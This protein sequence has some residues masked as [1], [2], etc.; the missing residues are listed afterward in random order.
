M[1][2]ITFHNTILSSHSSSTDIINSRNTKKYLVHVIAKLALSA[3]LYRLSR[4][5]K[6]APV[7]FTRSLSTIM[8]MKGECLLFFGLIKFKT[9]LDI[10]MMT[11]TSELGKWVLLRFFPKSRLSDGTFG[12]WFLLF[13]VSLIAVHTPDPEYRRSR[14]ERGFNIVGGLM[15]FR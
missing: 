10:F 2:S 12:Q 4:N 8:V 14:G 11:A 13:W 1:K 7:N 5:S 9:Y 3:W 6:P 15:F